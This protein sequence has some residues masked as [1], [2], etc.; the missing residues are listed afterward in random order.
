MLEEK[1]GT[2]R[3][4]PRKGSSS[5]GSEGKNEPARKSKVLRYGCNP[6]LADAPSH[7]PQQFRLSDSR[8][9]LKHYPHVLFVPYAGVTRRLWDTHVGDGDC[10]H[11]CPA[12]ALWEPLFW[13]VFRA[14]VA[15]PLGNHT[16]G[17]T[18]HAR[19]R[20]SHTR[21][22]ASHSDHQAI[23]PAMLGTSRM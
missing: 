21:D 14:L 11:F 3:G 2:Q 22:H 7:D 4:P 18:S 6:L 9:V 16:R 10:T 8:A 12:P 13:A 5:K 19:D 23:I 1:R 15:S 20:T 17:D